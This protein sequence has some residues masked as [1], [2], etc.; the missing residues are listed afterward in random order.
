[1][2]GVCVLPCGLHTVAVCFQHHCLSDC[3]A[4]DPCLWQCLLVLTRMGLAVWV[5][6]AGPPDLAA[7]NLI[8]D[9]NQLL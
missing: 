8:I 6:L 3:M 4:P 2:A 9:T 1:M 5:G 7:P